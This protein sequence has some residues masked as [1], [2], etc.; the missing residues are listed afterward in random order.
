MAPKK[1]TK[2]TCRCRG[3]SNSVSQ[4]VNVITGG[5]VGSHAIPMP[6]PI[7]VPMP[8]QQPTFISGMSRDY[9]EDPRFPTRPVMRDDYA[10]STQPDRIEPVSRLPISDDPNIDV[11]P[12]EVAR[13]RAYIA[14][15]EISETNAPSTSESTLVPDIENIKK[16]EIAETNA[17]FAS[18]SALVSD[19]ENL[20]KDELIKILVDRQ[21]ITAREVKKRKMN[22]RTL[23]AMIRGTSN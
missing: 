2:K 22:K 8:T 12:L 20:K 15:D 4:K 16:E 7:H 6:I 1:K 13:R 9:G 19:I 23:I 3:S 10:Y 11:S 14:P 17:K 21:A 18:E 5:G